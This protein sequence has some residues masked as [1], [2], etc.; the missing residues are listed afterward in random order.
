MA[1]KDERIRALPG[2]LI[3]RIV[4]TVGVY[5]RG[6]PALKTGHHLYLRAHVEHG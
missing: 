3:D 2:Q 4:D 6:L 5:S 1:D